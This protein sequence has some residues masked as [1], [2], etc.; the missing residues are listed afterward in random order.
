MVYRRWRNGNRGYLPDCTH[1]CA[2]RLVFSENTRFRGRVKVCGVEGTACEVPCVQAYEHP[3]RKW[4][5]N[6]VCTFVRVRYNISISPGNINYTSVYIILLSKH[7]YL[8]YTMQNA[9]IYNSTVLIQQ[10]PESRRISCR[11]LFHSPP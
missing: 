1:R 9:C 7:N 11:P 8:N 5:G 2:A 3:C 4:Y 10:K 6:Y